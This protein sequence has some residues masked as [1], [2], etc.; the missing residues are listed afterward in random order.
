MAFPRA[1]IA[2]TVPEAGSRWRTR[3]TWLTDGPPRAQNNWGFLVLYALQTGNLPRPDE[4]LPPPVM[5]LFGV[6]I[7]AVFGIG[8]RAS[9]G[10]IRCQRV[11]AFGFFIAG[12]V[13]TPIMLVAL[14]AYAMSGRPY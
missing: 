1:G 2:G 9:F 14:A 11:W 12:I 10:P 5:F 3:R 13:V 7:G 4:I 6:V 8:V